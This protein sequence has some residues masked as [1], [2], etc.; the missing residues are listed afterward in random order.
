MKRR[1]IVVLIGLMA[2]LSIAGCGKKN[3]SQPAA[4]SEQVDSKEVVTEEN[5]R[6][7]I[8]RKAMSVLREH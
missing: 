8:G 1:L 2:V 6:R 7:L 3:D 5:L 4:V